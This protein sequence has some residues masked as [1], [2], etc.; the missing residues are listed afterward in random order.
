MRGAQGFRQAVLTALLPA[1]A[2]ALLLGLAGAV[3][4]GRGALGRIEGVTRTIERIVNG[5]LSER[6]ASDGR[7]GD[8]DRLIEVVNGMLDE[9]ERLVHEVKGVTEDIAHDLRTPLTRLLA[10][11]ERVHRA[12]SVAEDET[13]MG[14]IGAA[15]IE[16]KSILATF[17]A[18]LRIAEVESGARRAG[19]I[20][21]DLNTVA[22]DVAEFYEPVAET[23]GTSLSLES[24]AE[25]SAETA[26]DPTLL[27]EAI[28]NL[29][30]NAIKYSP[31]GSSVRM[32]VVATRDRVGIEV[33]DTGS[34]IPEEERD[35][36]LRRFHRVD[37]SR[38]VPGAGLG[39]N[40]VAAVAKLHQ[41]HLAIEDAC[42]GCRVV[43]WSDGPPPL[44]AS[45]ASAT[46]DL[47]AR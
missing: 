7:R 40:L 3:V 41:F 47:D 27:F 17:A 30:E 21:V 34:G 13:A 46:S 1:A 37:R 15:I 6:L 25:G 12:T 2:A 45:F 22:A 24:A 35:T 23:K 31:S 44:S 18:L 14:A 33:S 42:P 26:G 20:T 5:N 39:L 8:I 10:G 32:R 11:L 36:V 28:S 38:T 9:I 29:V 16:T 19:F 43:L 4:A